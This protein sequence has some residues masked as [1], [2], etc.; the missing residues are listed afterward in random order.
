MFWTVLLDP[1][2]TV[3]GDDFVPECFTHL[4]LR[5][6]KRSITANPCASTQMVRALPELKLRKQLSFNC[7][8][9]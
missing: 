6:F 4:I 8:E 7:V 5:D 2:N 9:H 3:S 1:E